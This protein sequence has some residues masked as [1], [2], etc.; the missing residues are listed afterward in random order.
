MQKISLIR[1]LISSPDIL[2]LDEA[3]SNVDEESKVV[4]NKM[5]NDLDITVINCAHNSMGYK[6]NKHFTIETIKDNRIV[7]KL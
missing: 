1:A 5:L 3:T 4:I 2:L 7:K 6:H